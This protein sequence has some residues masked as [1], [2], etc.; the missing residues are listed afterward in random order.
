MTKKQKWRRNSLDAFGAKSQKYLRA[1]FHHRRRRSR[2]FFCGKPVG[3]EERTGGA[4]DAMSQP[5]P[6]P[7]LHS[8]TPEIPK[9]QR[10]AIAGPS[11]R[12]QTCH[13]RFESRRSSSVRLLIPPGQSSIRGENQIEHADDTGMTNRESSIGRLR[14]F[15]NIFIPA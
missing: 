7:L 10:T 14:C 9:K 5:V 11:V 4:G 13:R 8:S 15:M 6:S 3:G 2:Q 12:P 1:K